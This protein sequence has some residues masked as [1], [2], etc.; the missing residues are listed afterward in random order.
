MFGAEHRKPA[1][2]ERSWTGLH[3][4]RKALAEVEG[5]RRGG[6]VGNPVGRRQQR[7]SQR[8]FAGGG[9]LAVVPV[10]AAGEGPIGS[11]GGDS[12]VEHRQL[13]QPMMQRNCQGDRE[14]VGSGRSWCSSCDPCGSPMMRSSVGKPPVYI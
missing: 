12:A 7:P 6:P 14:S 4:H 11:E 10:L 3:G 9:G 2:V 5:G 1:A 8:D 13:H